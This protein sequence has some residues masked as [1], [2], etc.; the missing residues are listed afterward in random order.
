MSASLLYISSIGM[1]RECREGIRIVIIGYGGVYSL[2][3]GG[4]VYYTHQDKTT[5]QHNIR[6]QNG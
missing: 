6:N 1:S 4:E 2:C 5:Q 3:L